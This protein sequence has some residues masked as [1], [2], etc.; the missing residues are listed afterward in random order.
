MYKAWRSRESYYRKKYP[1]LKR[2]GVFSEWLGFLLLEM[3][4]GN[5]ESYLKLLRSLTFVVFFIGLYEVYFIMNP[6]AMNSYVEAAKNAPQVFLG[7]LQPIGFP[8][9]ALAV[10]A[11]AR[12]VMLAGLVS[13]LVKRFS[14][15]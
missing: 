4:W 15:R 8:G 12:Y 9:L 2:F 7:I 10:I 13:I 1:G 11:I 5:G 6:M 14:R 3:L